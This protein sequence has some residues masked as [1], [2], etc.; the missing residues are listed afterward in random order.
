MD[1]RIQ[2]SD[3]ALNDLRQICDWYDKRESGV[4]ADFRTALFAKLH[5]I[6]EMPEANEIVVRDIRRAIM[7][8]FPYS[9]YY[10]VDSDCI[11]IWAIIH[12][13]RSSRVW[14]LRLRN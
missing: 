2:F 6:V 1:D 9:I 7:S 14:R 5:A 13:S 8:D 12:H 3:A 4:G 11:A 10:E